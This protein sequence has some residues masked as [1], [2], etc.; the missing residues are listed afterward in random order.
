MNF[1]VT[2]VKDLLPEAGYFTLPKRRNGSL[3]M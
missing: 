1:P 3:F 2:V